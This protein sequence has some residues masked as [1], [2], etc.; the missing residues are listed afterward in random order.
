MKNYWRKQKMEPL[1]FMF[2]GRIILSVNY[3]SM[4]CKGLIPLNPFC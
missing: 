3:V 4:I 2:L 1:T